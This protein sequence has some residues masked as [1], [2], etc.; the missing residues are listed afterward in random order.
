MAKSKISKGEQAILDNDYYMDNCKK[1]IETREY[2][3]NK[4]KELGFSVTDSKA[5]FIFAK[6]DKIDGKELY[7]KLKE[8]GILVRHFDKEKIKD[9]NR[10]TV[11][12]K[13]EMDA[14]LCA[15]VD[16]LKEF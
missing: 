7:L 1:I 9:Y 12:T 3:Q 11:G 8:R 15:I 5:N 10:I 4:L 6:S 16:I 14:L 13:E 2:T